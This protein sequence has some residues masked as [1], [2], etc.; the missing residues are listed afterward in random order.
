MFSRHV[1]LVPNEMRVVGL[2]T[3]AT[4]PLRFAE[5]WGRKVRRLE[6]LLST[7]LHFVWM[8]QRKKRSAEVEFA[9]LENSTL[10]YPLLVARLFLP[11]PLSPIALEYIHV[12]N[13]APILIGL[14]IARSASLLPFSQADIRE[15]GTLTEHEL[16]DAMR[17]VMGSTPKAGETSR[18]LR[19]FGDPG[20]EGEADYAEG[21]VGV[22][23][24]GVVYPAGTEHLSSFC[25]IYVLRVMLVR[26][27]QL[28]YLALRCLAYAFYF[29]TKI[30]S[31]LHNC[32]ITYSTRAGRDPTVVSLGGFEAA[33]VGRLRESHTLPVLP[34]GCDELLFGSREDKGG[35]VC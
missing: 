25:E 28:P 10:S 7:C 15:S 34:Q 20:S 13:N 27:F 4:F 32:L 1:L 23:G 22:I 14:Y 35:Q 21:I 30:F 16:S 17:I 24:M 5:V 33:M 11:N 2:E 6:H 19:F 26:L 31:P 18:V 8:K 12:P 3:I 29:N 9:F